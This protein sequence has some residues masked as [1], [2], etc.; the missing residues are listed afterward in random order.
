[1]YNIGRLN[2]KS[3]EL[4][5]EQQT[6][7]FTGT[8]G[9]ATGSKVKVLDGG[10]TWLVTASYYDHRFR[11]IQSVS[12]NYK[13][14][15]DRTTNVIEF[16]SGLVTKTKTVHVDQDV[17]WKNKS[18]F[19]LTGNRLSNS[20]PTPGWGYSGGSSSQVLLAN[21]DGWV[22]VTVVDPTAN[23]WLIGLS[24]S[25]PNTL[26]NSIN[27]AIGVG[28]A[29]QVFTGENSITG[30][31]R[32]PVAAGDVLKVD[33]TAGTVRY[34]KN[35][36]LLAT[37]PGTSTSALLVDAAMY[38][39]A[40]T[41]S[42][43]RTSFETKTQTT[44]RRFSYD[45]S[46][47]S[48]KTWHKFNGETEVLLISNEYNELGQQVDKQ[49]HSTDN[50]VTGKQSIDY[51]YNIRGWITSVNGAELA[52]SPT[53]KND[54]G[55][56]QTR[57][58][59]G[60]DLLYQQVDSELGN[61]G[62]FNG[63]ITA[64][65]WSYN[66]GLGTVKQNA[67]KYAYDAINRLASAEFA[68]R[69]TAWQPN[70]S[71][72]YNE[73][74]Y[75]YDL[76]GNILSLTRRD[77]TGTAMDV[78]TYDYGA[79]IMKT[80]RLLKVG[81]TGNKAEGFVDGGNVVNDYTYDAN[82]NVT[83]DQ[84]KGM[85]TA[86]TYNHLN[87]PV[88]IYRGG[89]SGSLGY[90]Y[91]AVG[92][93][94]SRVTSAWYTRKQTDY[95]G[96][97]EYLEDDL[98]SVRHEE[99]RIVLKNR[100][101]M[102]YTDG[103]A[104]T[105]L[106][107]TSCT[108]TAVTQNSNQTYLRAVSNGTVTRTGLQNVTGVIPVSAGEKFL[109]R[110]KGYSASYDVYIL[111]QVNGVDVSWLTKFPQ[112]TPE[113]ESWVETIFTIPS[114]GN[115]TAG[116]AWNTVANGS[117]FYLNDFEVVKISNLAAPEYQYNIKDHMGNVRVTF[118]S[119]DE[120]DNS[121]ATLETANAVAEQGKFLYYN[122]A[123]KVNSTLF[124]HTNAGTTYYATRLNG[125]SNERTGLAKSLSVMAGDV[126]NVQVFAKYLD[127]NTSNWTTALNGLMTSIA[128][129]SAPGGTFID[130]G[131]PGSTGGITTPYMGLLDKSG[132]TG[133]AP[134]AYLNYLVFDRNYMV[135][136]Q[137][138]VRMTTAGREYGQDASH[139]ELSKS[140]TIKEPGYVYLFLSNDNAALGGSQIEVYFDDFKV[141]HI[142]SIIVQSQ[143]YY[144][145]GLTFN[146]YNRENAL[147]NQYQYNGKEMQDELG[148]GW[149]DYGA[150]MYQP[151]IGRW[152]VIDGKSELYFA[153]TPFA[154][155]LNQP[156]NAVDPDGN[157]VI[158]ING[159]HL[160]TGGKPEYWRGYASVKVGERVLRGMVDS[161]PQP[162]YEIQEVA[163][164]DRSVMNHLGDQ[165]AMYI[166]GGMGGL[167]NSDRNG[168]L[169]EGARREAGY[170]KGMEDAE[171]IIENL[172][173][174]KNGSITESIKVI[175]HSWG[176]AFGKGYAKAILDYAR[177]NKIAGV[178]IAFEADFAPFQPWG[179]Q[180]IED[181]N[182][183]PTLQFSHNADRVAGNKPVSGAEQKDTSG[184]ESQ[185]HSI[186]SFSKQVSALPT[187]TY[188]VKNGTIIPDKK[189]E[190][191]E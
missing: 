67:Y 27:Y 78:L 69:T 44:V 51:S 50:G 59:F 103:V 5:G 15:T 165:N 39:L 121:L 11:V 191:N 130:G 62:L 28:S 40:S 148:L 72:A 65:K 37:A 49:L 115:L 153:T 14:G 180:A 160:G 91:D 135:K 182:M 173:R 26:S 138:F 186:L 111:A 9:L 63:N 136:D 75:S 47:R 66:Q 76:N 2:F 3:D 170:D 177:Q 60:M 183:G 168:N 1:M 134:K 58:L 118:T 81:D 46:G 175:T 41:F 24:A 42:N 13:G 161:K 87:L 162:I 179:Q 143:D 152:G 8:K 33:R 64:V 85:I 35:G 126:V 30:T 166:D 107:C 154:Y 73:S 144:P 172:A 83:T 94:L 114:S 181:E 89:N 159:G 21:T 102:F 106:T 55:A 53:P 77:K 117:T 110:A 48:L 131:T 176:G 43:V 54:D 128:N 97:Y 56:G 82:G 150:R 108:L 68:E 104:T 188:T 105:G 61:A 80:N 57:D 101:Q 34:Y 190:D 184:D 84:N 147:N 16:I 142:K 113:S 151:E 96:E 88:S 124:D 17:T 171:M 22:E 137:G 90:I 123:V 174:D 98:Q 112:S 74:G 70:T 158:F 29:N 79:G 45:H 169:H 164:F 189:K 127:P 109:V 36:T 139:E 156:T 10:Y 146:S 32:G 23:A 141:D 19:I 86:A 71:L 122:E 132:D 155:A 145:F 12:D 120:T 163:A 185:G 116:L 52:A 100:E 99:G 125:S 133:P 7:F 20:S 129:G 187:G 149:L 119:R 92:R 31:V 18:N 157:L 25:D 93:K 178:V 140:L 167:L 95:A 4:P 6:T 38:S